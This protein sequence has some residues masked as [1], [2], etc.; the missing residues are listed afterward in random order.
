MSIPLMLKEWRETWWMGLAALGFLLLLVLT[1]MGLRFDDRHFRLYWELQRESGWWEPAPFLRAD[2]SQI[3]GI[4]AC[5]LGG[6]LG[7]WQT[8]GESVR[9][10]WAYLL[11]RPLRRGD[12]VLTKLLFG[13]GLLLLS[14]GIPLLTYLVWAMLPGT[15]AQPFELW[16]T[17]ETFRMWLGG[18]L[19]YL[20]AFLVGIRAARFYVSRLWPLVLAVL[21]VF[22]V[23]EQG[24]LPGL[25]SWLIV[26]SD[27]VLIAAIWFAAEDRDYA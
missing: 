1:E 8:L 25:N 17:T 23:S 22:A 7:L 12:V 27:V 4:T 10:T 15:H 9:G 3:V 5:I 16:M 6:V 26:V 2:F 19:V 24:I 18:T 14:T 11:H 21:I 20:A 13:G